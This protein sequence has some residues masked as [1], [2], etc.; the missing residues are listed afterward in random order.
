M[1]TSV[2]P[3]TTFTAQALAMSKTLSQCAM[4]LASMLFCPA[5]MVRQNIKDSSYSL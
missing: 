4:R 2:V 1:S 3:T 5:M